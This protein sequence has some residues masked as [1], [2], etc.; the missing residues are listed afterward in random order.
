MSKN[1]SSFIYMVQINTTIK[2]KKT[3]D[4]KAY[5]KE[6]QDKNKDRILY[7]IKQNY[8]QNR[9]KKLEYMRTPNT[10]QVCDG[11]FTNVNK[12]QHLASKKHIESEFQKQFLRYNQ[13]FIKKDEN[14]YELFSDYETSEE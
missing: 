10:C 11:K 9:D 6:Y 1:I 7:K 12:Q 13:S 8:I 3:A 4:M 2:I 14:S 5:Q